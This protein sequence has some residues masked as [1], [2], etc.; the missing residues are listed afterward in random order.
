LMFPVSMMN[1]RAGTSFKVSGMSSSI[2][3]PPGHVVERR[4]LSLN[5]DDFEL[6]PTDVEDL[7]LIAH[8]G[9]G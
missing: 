2:W 9:V 4:I 1:S 7:I 6:S 8:L 5:G 3:Y